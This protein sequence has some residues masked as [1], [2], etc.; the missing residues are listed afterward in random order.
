MVDLYNNRFRNCLPLISNYLYEETLLKKRTFRTSCSSSF[1]GVSI[2]I[3]SEVISERQSSK[4][5]NFRSSVEYNQELHLPWFT[6]RQV[7]I[8][9]NSRHIP[10]QAD[11]KLKEIATCSPTFSVREAV[12]EFFIQSPHCLFV[13]FPFHLIDR[14]NWLSFGLMTLASEN[15]FIWESLFT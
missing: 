13:M 4:E 10:Q 9:Q 15:T 1:S 2:Y 14:C 3:F 8:P 7:I 6:V 11:S 12:C 5:G